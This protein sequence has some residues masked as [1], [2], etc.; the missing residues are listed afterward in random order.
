MSVVIPIDVRKQMDTR[1]C[2]R[3]LISSLVFAFLLAPSTLASATE[4]HFDCGTDSSPVLRGFERLTADEVYNTSR[5]Y[6]WLG[7]RPM[8]VEFRRPERNMQLRGS[9]SDQLLQEPYDEHR[10]PLNRDGVVSRQDIGFRLD[11]PNA[12][13]RVSVTMGSLTNAIG[14]IDL[15]VNGALVAEQ[16]AVW[17]PGGYRMLDRTPAGW[18]TTFRTTAEVT[19]GAIRINWKKNQ[20]HYDA[21]MAEQATW[22][23]PYAQWYHSTPVLQDPPYHYIGYPFAGHSIMA[24]EVTPYRPGPMAMVDGAMHG[25]LQVELFQQQ[26]DPQ[27]GPIDTLGKELRWQRRRDGSTSIRTVTRLAVTFAAND[28]TIN[29]GFDF[30]LFAG[31]TLPKVCK[32]FTAAV[33]DFFILGKV[34]LFL[35]CR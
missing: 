19:D 7:G 17:S 30:D 16:L 2:R 4:V 34:A 6:G 22:E 14:S 3:S 35:A 28:S 20:A 9:L 25:P 18:W 33:T 1:S 5:G 29:H 10:N 8:H 15:S 23:T 12:I 27:A 32:R 24:I 21:Q 11:L 13:Y 31:I 26:M